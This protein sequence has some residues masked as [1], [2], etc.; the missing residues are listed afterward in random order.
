M[1]LIGANNAVVWAFNQALVS[2]PILDVTSGGGDQLAISGT[3]ISTDPPGFNYLLSTPT[4]CTF[5]LQLPTPDMA[6]ITVSSSSSSFALNAVTPDVL[7]SLG[8]NVPP[9]LMSGAA[10]TRDLIGSATVV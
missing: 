10:S 8:A 5:G 7:L 2:D 3:S 1:T 6:M 9:P 4:D